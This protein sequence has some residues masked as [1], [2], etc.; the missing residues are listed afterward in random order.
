M[1]FGRLDSNLRGAEEALARETTYR[2]IRGRGGPS[3][4][5]LATAAMRYIGAA[6]TTLPLLLF[7]VVLGQAYGSSS[8]AAAEDVVASAPDPTKKKREALLRR[9]RLSI[10]TT[11]ITDSASLQTAVTAWCSDA[12]SAEATYGHISDWDTSGVEDM[13]FL[14]GTTGELFEQDDGSW[15][16]GPGQYCSSYRT[17]NEDIS[18]WNVSSVTTTRNMFFDASSFNSDVSAWDVSSVED[19][20]QM[21][22]DA[23]SFN[24]DVSQWDVGRV[25]ARG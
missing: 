9:R 13:S 23:T 21:F 14:F 16:P 7:A 1:E 15:A 24:S 4:H 12:T 19:M 11:A 17:F 25:T 18:K 2:Q 20:Y 3:S 22:R 10:T 5:N 8:V 6:A